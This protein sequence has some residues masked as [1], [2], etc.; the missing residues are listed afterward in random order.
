MGGGQGGGFGDLAQRANPQF[1]DPMQNLNNQGLP[2]GRN[3]MGGS[4]QGGAPGPGPGGMPKQPMSM[5]PMSMPGG[6]GMRMDVPPPGAPGGGPAGP[7]G[8]PPGGARRLPQP[9]PTPLPA[10]PGG[11][12]L[13]PMP[14]PPMGGAGQGNPFAGLMAQIQAGGAIPGP[15][16]GPPITSMPAKPG[17]QLPPGLAGAFG[18]GGPAGPGAG[19]AGK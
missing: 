18:G 6:G 10:P 11:G 3:I 15:G 9:G 16:G 14:A 4:G 12:I 1:S 5:G 2:R 13:K 7:I 8:P 17:P 19:P